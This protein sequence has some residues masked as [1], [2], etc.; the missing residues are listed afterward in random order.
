MNHL[1]SKGWVCVDAFK[2]YFKQARDELGVRLA[3][4]LFDEDGSKNK[5]WQ[6]FIQFDLFKKK[7][8]KCCM[9]VY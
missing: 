1:K 6:V 5:W 8:S 7:R 9:S 4:R 3:N 2:A